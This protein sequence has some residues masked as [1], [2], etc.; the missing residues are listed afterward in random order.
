MTGD[1]TEP[2]PYHKFRTGDTFATIRMQLAEEARHVLEREGRRMFVTRRTV[3]GRWRQIKLASYQGYV[4]SFE[5][6]TENVTSE[7]AA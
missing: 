7:D 2:V 4:R 5:D 1:E 6:V 3:L